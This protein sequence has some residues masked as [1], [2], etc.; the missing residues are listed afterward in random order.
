MIPAAK[1]KT[2]LPLMAAAMGAANTKSSI[3]NGLTLL[4][5]IFFSLGQISPFSTRE[6]EGKERGPE[7]DDIGVGDGL[8]VIG[9]D[10]N[11]ARCVSGP[12]L[13]LA[14]RRPACAAALLRLHRLRVQQSCLPTFFFFFFGNQK[15]IIEKSG[16]A[17]FYLSPSSRFI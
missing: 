6:E 5:T 10:M 3:I 16:G 13:R 11:A 12:K 7:D 2:N 1:L 9:G 15:M 17:F 4:H 14:F 8:H